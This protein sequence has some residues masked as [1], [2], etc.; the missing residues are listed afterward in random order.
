M[1]STSK[2][3]N[4]FPPDEFKNYKMENKLL[5][6]K[7]FSAFIASSDTNNKIEI[8]DLSPEIVTP[9]NWQIEHKKALLRDEKS[10]YYKSKSLQED[11]DDAGPII[12]IGKILVV[13]DENGFFFAKINFIKHNNE[14]RFMYLYVSG[15]RRDNYFKKGIKDYERSC[16]IVWKFAS[17]ISE[18]EVII[19][20]PREII[21]KYLF[22]VNARFYGAKSSNMRDLILCE[23][24][25]EDPRNF[26]EG[27][28]TVFNI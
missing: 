27:N 2:E 20:Y 5:H 23:I 21:I 26:G 28:V 11:L 24:D 1:F 6:Y 18:G 7:N 12:N 10:E 15:D 19:T 8:T 14:F 25:W 17:M 4:F 22:R 16:F 13:L 3:R 9:E